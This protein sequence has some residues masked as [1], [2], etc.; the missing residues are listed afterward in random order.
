M[1]NDEDKK[2]SVEVFLSQTKILTTLATTFL[3]APYVV[4]NKWSFIR[5]ETF[6]CL[7]IYIYVII[8]SIFFL[9]SILMTYFI[10]S[11]IS[12]NA[13]RG[14]YDVYRAAT[15]F[16]SILQFSTLILGS[17]ILLPFIIIIIKGSSF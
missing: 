10:Y 16:F 17:L 8:S 13:D 2:Y 11:S 6:L 15:R 12:G 5:N 4:F 9:I 14:V 1:A 7:D 3:I